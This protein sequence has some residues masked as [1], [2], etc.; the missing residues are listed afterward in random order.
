MAVAGG[1]VLIVVS[2][3]TLG[4]LF[5]PQI[6]IVEGHRIVRDGPYRRRRRPISTGMLL[7]SLD[8]AIAL[9][10]IDGILLPVPIGAIGFGDRVRLEERMLARQFSDADEE[11]ARSTSRL[12]PGIWKPVRRAM[13]ASRRPL[14][15]RQPFLPPS[16]WR[17]FAE[18][19]TGRR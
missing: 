13:A 8:R 11:H 2:I 10:G 3:R 6:R 12:L 19:R 5:S 1:I 4:R 15:V 9:R 17:A 18:A 14:D 16:G 7:A